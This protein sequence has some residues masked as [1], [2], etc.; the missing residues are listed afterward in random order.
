[1]IYLTVPVCTVTM[2]TITENVLKNDDLWETDLLV[3]CKLLT[4]RVRLACVDRLWFLF[5]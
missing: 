1:M 4:Q 3:K 5:W 2:E